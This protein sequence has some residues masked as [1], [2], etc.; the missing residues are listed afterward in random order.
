MA[1]RTVPLIVVAVLVAGP[2]AAQV[3]EVLEFA[4]PSR[5]GQVTIRAELLLPEGSSSGRPAMIIHHGS[6]GVGEREHSYARE[7]LAMGVAAIVLDSF[8]SRGVKD[9]VANQ[10]AVSN[11][12]MLA[13]AFN[14]LRAAIQHPRLDPARIGIVG[15]SK[16]GTVALQ[17]GLANVAERF[18]P[19]GPRFALHVPFYPGCGTQYR[20][21]RTAG[22]PMLVLI[23]GADTYVGT[24]P[25]VSYAAKIKAAGGNVEAVVYPNAQ[26]GW[27]SAPRS[28]QIPNG[29]NY[30]K[31]V[32]IE[33]PDGSWIEQTS[34]VTTHG[35]GGR[36]IEGAARQAAAGCRTL[37]VSGG[38]DA[39]AKAKSLAALKS[40][41]KAAL[42]LD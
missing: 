41:V 39:D 34:G 13:D 5:T 12:D 35:P 27:D 22:A 28:Y 21:A 25:C 32:F 42:R 1:R 7:F 36:P 8:T 10:S 18:A 29:E 30:S 31:C 40:A 17:S 19:G 37:G 15:F 38:P 16:G 33:Q 3:K 11:N 9:T 20:D 4:G 23:G 14:A 6:G 2:A 26:H 24:Q